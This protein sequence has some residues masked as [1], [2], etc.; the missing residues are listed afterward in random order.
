MQ[1]PEGML[2]ASRPNSVPRS[3]VK[4]PKLSIT[5]EPEANLSSSGHASWF[6]SLSGS[7]LL[8]ESWQNDASDAHDAEFRR[9]PAGF[10]ADET[11]PA[12][13]GADA[14]GARRAAT[15]EAPQ[16]AGADADLGA[17]P[18]ALPG[19]EPGRVPEAEVVE[20]AGPSG[21]RRAE[22]GPLGEPA[23]E[24]VAGAAGRAGG[25]DRRTRSGGEGGGRAPSGGG[26][27]DEAQG[28][29][30]GDRS[31]LRADR[32]SGRAFCEQPQAG[33]LSGAEPGRGFQRRSLTA[34]APPQT[35][36]TQSG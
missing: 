26:R 7:L 22:L 4:M 34:G 33:Q 10:A 12:R 13:L 28:R 18:V 27:A 21:A 31:G 11:L 29:G 24:G 32:R 16:Q 30:A 23:A 36:E 15:A 19:H 5:S 20:R 3:F 8:R 2:G 25:G 35:K 14:G 6:P 1:S 17:E 9:A